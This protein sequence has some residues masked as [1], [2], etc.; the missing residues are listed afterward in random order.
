[1]YFK[2]DGTRKIKLSVSRPRRRMRGNKV[3]TP[4]ILNL[5]TRWWWVFTF[6]RGERT[7]VPS[8]Q[9]AGRF[10]NLLP[11]RLETLN[12]IYILF[13]WPVGLWVYQTDLQIRPVKRTYRLGLSNGPTD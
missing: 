1:M 9:D 7:P 11:R 5:D 4:L 8:E 2:L 13:K 6:L 12:R 10:Y 3:K